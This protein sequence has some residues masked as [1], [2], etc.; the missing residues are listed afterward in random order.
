MLPKAQSTTTLK[1]FGL[2]ALILLALA[3]GGAV[4]FVL[5]TEEPVIN[6]DE[7]FP[8]PV[9]L[10]PEKRPNFVFPV[11]ARTSDLSLNRF[12][13]RFAR[14]CMQGKY[15]DFRLMM[16]NRHPPILPPRFE[17]NFNALKQVRVLGL[18]KLPEMPEQPG[19]VYIMTA[20]YELQDY[21]V[22][23]G[24]KIKQ[25]QVAIAKEAGEWRLGPIPSEA[26]ARLRAYQSGASESES[27]GPAAEG[28]P[29]GATSRSAPKAT[30]NVPARLDS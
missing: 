20:E 19:P 22:R 1:R 21:A 5:A 9:I 17:S 26:L 24:E 15:S 23:G 28:Q 11:A 25:A 16:S 18:E 10:D 3:F 27:D 4:I 12:V 6:A 2:Y 14:V 8:E 7:A 30:A 29:R 13:D